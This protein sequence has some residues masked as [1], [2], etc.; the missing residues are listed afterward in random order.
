[1]PYDAHFDIQS[2]SLHEIGELVA[3]QKLPPLDQW[4]PQKTGDSEME[5]LPDGTWLHQGGVIKRPAMVRAFSR[6]LY[7]DDNGKYWLKTPYEQLSIIVSDAPLIAVELT[8]KGDGVKQRLFFRLNN[9]EIIAADAKQK[10]FLKQGK[11]EDDG[12]IFHISLPHGLFAKAS[13]AVHFELAELICENENGNMG[14]WSQN[15]FFNL[16]QMA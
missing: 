10:I 4:Q 3:E 9:D 8:K 16:G 6:L 12:D 1:M 5:I 11:G 14:I 13:R 7:C 2:L 15:Q